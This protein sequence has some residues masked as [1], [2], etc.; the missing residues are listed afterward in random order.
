MSDYETV[1]E[2]LERAEADC[3]DI[4]GPMSACTLCESIAPAS[5]IQ[6]HR[7]TCPFA[8]LAQPT[9]SECDGFC[10]KGRYCPEHGDLLPE[11]EKR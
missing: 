7:A 11:S 6:S 3:R 10:P 9:E 5:G 1:R 8:V 4:D 2:A